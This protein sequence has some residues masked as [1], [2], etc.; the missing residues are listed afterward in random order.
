M[1]GH[2]HVFRSNMDAEWGTQWGIEL[3]R[4]SV[5]WSVRELVDSSDWALVALLWDVV[6]AAPVDC[7]EF[8]L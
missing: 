1:R 5:G 6:S 2:T 8:S 4:M 3:E 7:T